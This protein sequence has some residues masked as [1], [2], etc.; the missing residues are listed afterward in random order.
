[1]RNFS[2][3]LFVTLALCTA[4]V[5]PATA[6]ADDD[7]STPAAEPPAH[8]YVVLDT[9]KGEIVLELHPEWSELGVAHFKQLVDAG[10]YDGAPWF[11]VIDGFV[12]Q[13]GI[14]SDPEMNTQWENAN[15][16]DEKVVMGNQRGYVS[17]GMTGEPDSRSTHF[18]INYVD[19]S[20][21][22]AR[23]FAAFAVVVQGMDVADSLARV[24]FEDQEGLAKEGGMDAFAA[25]FPDADYI[26]SAFVTDAWE[27]DDEESYDGEDGAAA[28]ATDKG[29]QAAG[30]G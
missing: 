28:A 1:M 23:G 15:I 8:E 19:N 3:N 7:S 21:L 26:D 11:R 6:R 16:K 12:A 4:A 18:Y 13:C 17:Y 20:R 2:L 5:L 22:D 10:F 30:K 29:A 27:P 24:E 14:S 25:R 9:T